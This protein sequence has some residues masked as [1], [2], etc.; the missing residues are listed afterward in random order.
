MSD[1]NNTF[2]QPVVSKSEMRARVMKLEEA[3][4]QLPQAKMFL[5]HYFAQGLYARE[6]FIPAGCV[7]T[8]KIHLTEHL[9]M[10]VQGEM[11]LLTED[12]PQHVMAPAIFVSR[13]GAKRAGVAY[14]DSRFV[15]I[16]ATSETN[17]DR[18]EAELT[19]DSF[20]DPRLAHNG[21]SLPCLI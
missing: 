4:L 17:I 21:E 10:L 8:G 14:T 6:L 3:L 19:A 15:C 1:L 12:G 7:L 20:E 9:A 18:L 5:K 16:H 2:C 11:E 13:A